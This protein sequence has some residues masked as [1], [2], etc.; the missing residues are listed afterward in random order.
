[1]TETGPLAE[2]QQSDE[3]VSRRRLMLY[4]TNNGGYVTSWRLKY[5]ESLQQ[6]GEQ[7]AKDHP[8]GSTIIPQMIP[9]PE[10]PTTAQELKGPW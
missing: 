3:A 4:A 1:M 9:H 5:V 10:P 8:G 2:A 6:S 7:P